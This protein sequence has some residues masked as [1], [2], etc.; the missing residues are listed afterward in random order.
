MIIKSEIEVMK[1]EYGVQK[2]GV[3]STQIKNKQWETQTTVIYIVSVT[4]KTNYW[5]WEEHKEMLMD[6]PESLES[7]IRDSD[8][9]TIIADINCKIVK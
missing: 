7:T 3:R 4:S 6:I 9:V 1:L 2:A 5:S 8:R